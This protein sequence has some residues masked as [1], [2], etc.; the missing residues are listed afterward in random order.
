MPNLSLTGEEIKKLRKNLIFNGTSGLKSVLKLQMTS[1]S[2]NAYDVTNFFVFFLVLSLY[3]I[4]TEFHCCQT[5]NGRVKL[6]TLSI[7]GVS[8]TLSKIGLTGWVAG[9][10]PFQC[11]VVAYCCFSPFLFFFRTTLFFLYVYICI[12]KRQVL[13]DKICSAGQD[14]LSKEYICL[15]RYDRDL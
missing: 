11:L 14:E 9:R 15:T 4:P 10:T 3:S 8:R 12:L 7:I 2:D 6:P 1:Y 13:P 5:P